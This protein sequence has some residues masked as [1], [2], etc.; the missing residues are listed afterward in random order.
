MTKTEHMKSQKKYGYYTPASL[1]LQSCGPKTSLVNIVKR[2]VF[3]DPANNKSYLM[4]CTTFIK[5]DFFLQNTVI[6]IDKKNK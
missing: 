4:H 3:H 2:F 6:E 1:V 5:A